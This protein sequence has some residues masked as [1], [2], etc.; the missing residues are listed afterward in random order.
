MIANVDIVKINEYHSI[1]DINTFMNEYPISD[2]KW[3]GV[4][5]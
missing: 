4:N 2:L 3:N 1:E 5:C